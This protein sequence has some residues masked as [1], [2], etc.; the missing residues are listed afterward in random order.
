MAFGFSFLVRSYAEKNNRS[1]ELWRYLTILFPFIAPVVLALLPLDPSVAQSVIGSSMGGL[2]SP[3][4]AAK[5]PFEERFPLLTQCLADQPAQVQ[6]GLRVRYQRVKA[7]FEFLLP[8]HPSAEAR[9]LAEAE[10][11]RLVTWTG[12]SGSLSLIYGAGLVRP[13]AVEETSRWLAAAVAPGQKLMIAYR[14]A[15]G[16]QQFTEH[17]IDRAAGQ[18]SAG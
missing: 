13:N 11:C 14:D 17:R 7:S 9:L 12:T 2:D 15:A 5:G 4:K 10:N 3:A 8:V 1:P 16:L 6:V 18:A